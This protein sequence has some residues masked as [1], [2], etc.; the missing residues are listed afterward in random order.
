MSICGSSNDS[1][2]CSRDCP[3]RTELTEMNEEQ[4]FGH[5]KSNQSHWQTDRQK[6]RFTNKSHSFKHQA[7]CASLWRRFRVCDIYTICITMPVFDAWT[8]VVTTSRIHRIKNTFSFLSI[9]WMIEMKIQGFQ[10]QQLAGLFRDFY[11]FSLRQAA[12]FRGLSLITHFNMKWWKL[13][14]YIL[15]TAEWK[16]EEWYFPT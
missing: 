11:L 6:A 10:C 5:A 3:D 15:I 2:I 9:L 12:I 16:N 7:L 14:F 13:W 1:V 8:M 4:L